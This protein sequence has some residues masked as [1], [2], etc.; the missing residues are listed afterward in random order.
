MRFENINP[1]DYDYDLPKGRIAQYP[2]NERDMSKLLILKDHKIS[3]DI[4]RNITEYIPGD[5]LL[6]FN[7][8]RVIRARLL[9]TKTTGA[10]IEILCL[11][12]LL[13]ADY[14][15]SF[16][17]P[18][19]VE[20]KCIIGNLKKWKGGPV[21]MEFQFDGKK[22]SLEAERLCAE[23]EASRVLFK[24]N[25]PGLSFS[26]VIDSAGHMP[27]PPYIEREDEENDSA[28]YQTVYSSVKGSV[29]AP[30]AGL[31]FTEN[32]LSE[33]RKS[34][35]N[36]TEITLHVG[37]GTFKPMKA[38]KISDHEMHCEHFTVSRENITA[39]IEKQGKIIPVG[40]TSVRTI[41]SLYWMGVKL[42]TNKKEHSFS[43][44]QWEPYHLNGDISSEVSLNALL[45]H[46]KRNNL[47]SLHA[48]TSIMIVPG[49][50]FKITNGLIT[51]FHQP[52]ST[53]LLLISAW[54]GEKW[55]DIYRYA[56]E[57]EFRFLSY[58]DSSLLFS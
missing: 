17:S 40:T 38:N 19:P 55:K 46:M 24:W 36:T 7:N 37:A 58:G 1:D 16:A 57:N 49:Y 23:G 41:E 43:L 14:E 29:A 35:I 26:E 31:H 5:S 4:F 52:R 51:N 15:S 54:T 25:A 39:L 56:K 3:Q 48:S 32:V 22:Y 30:T 53:L 13:P 8:S 50:N 47:L 45:E 10:Q 2:L 18:G 20:W 28:T 21:I 27:L 11:E 42:L 34:G 12:P 33:I 6:V 9:F 44:D